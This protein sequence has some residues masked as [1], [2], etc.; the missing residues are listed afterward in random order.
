MMKGSLQI[1]N[2]I[3][4][5]VFY[6]PGKKS[7]I[8]RSTGI[9]AQRGNKRKAEQKM[10]DIIAGYE[11]TML[12][13]DKLD[14]TKYIDIWLSS[15][16]KRVDIVT[17]EGYKSYIE[18]HIKPY[19]EVQNLKL[20][21]VTL[22]D[23]EKYFQYKAASGRL[24]GKSGGLS[25]RTIKLHS[26]VLNLIFNEAVRNSLIKDNPCKYAKIPNSV[27]KSEKHIDFYTTE[28][29]KKLLEVTEDAVLHDMIYITFIYGLR[30]SELLGLKWDAV[31]FD[32]DTIT[33]KHT[34]VLQNKIVAKDK[35][36][37]TTSNR[38]YPLLDD[39]K[40][41]LLKIKEQQE[42]YKKLFKGCY[43]DTGYI[44]TKPDGKAF[45]PSY[46]T[47]T[48]EK[49][50]KKNSLPHI[51]WHDLRHSC[52]SM[53]LLKGWKMKEISDWLGHASLQTTADIYSHLDMEHKRELGSSLG[54][55]LD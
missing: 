3:Y 46:P 35:T 42:D 14:F 54:G 12:D 34:V 7:A 38:T 51:R 24:D 36:K 13:E 16:K 55:I 5:A 1:K 30:R 44:F 48:L 49:V 47:H 4:Q 22:Q 9:K 45:Y 37:N 2:G 41:I 43:N 15:A 31:D 17:Y 26:V 28:Q 29:C 25:Y 50:L 10:A 27:K 53:L 20:Q 21:D 52:A 6:A 18:R 19:F 39:V 32:N 33:I 11:D 40:N 23:I 8:W